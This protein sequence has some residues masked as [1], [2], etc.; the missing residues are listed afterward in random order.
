MRFSLVLSFTLVS[1]CL[2]AQR[3]SLRVVATL[4]SLVSHKQKSIDSAQQQLTA[5]LTLRQS[6]TLKV[7][8]TLDSTR[9]ALQQTLA[10][11][12]Q[13]LSPDI[14]QRKL[15]SLNN[16]GS[17][18]Y[19][20]SLN[21]RIASLQQKINNPFSKVENAV[22][23]KLSFLKQETGDP[24]FQQTLNLPEATVPTLGADVPGIDAGGLNIKSATSAVTDKLDL[25]GTGSLDK[26]AGQLNK[27]SELSGKVDDYQ[28]EIANLQESG[29]RDSKEL[30]A[31]AEKQLANTDAMQELQQQV[32]K[33]NLPLNSLKSEDAAKA[34]LQQ[35]AKTEVVKLAKDHFAGKEEALT[36]AMQKMSGL[37]AKYESLDSLNVPKRMPNTMKGKPLK[38]RIVLDLMVQI[39]KNK[40]WLLDFNPS[41][42]Y[43]LTGRWSI[44]AGWNQRLAFAKGL[45][46]VQEEEIY[47]WRSF[48]EFRW[49]K[50]FSLR[51]EAEQMYCF[52]V[53]NQSASKDGV[54][55]RWMW[56]AFA[57]IKKNYRISRR[58]EGT[59]SLLYLVYD[60]ADSSPYVN[61]V[62][63]RLGIHY[64]F[65]K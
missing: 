50:G 30:S 52:P 42:T 27:V 17:L 1:L 49:A 65:R 40:Y 60:P 33:S 36:A 35:Q 7:F 38:E 62:N 22:N 2:H 53:V 46:I 58:L 8:R 4:D 47:G 11:A 14:I 12:D 6:D 9:T 43:A 25:P 44:G 64:R 37:K 32:G 19:L 29:L 16:L 21:Q 55:A 39:Q 63:S 48:T 45:E 13:A 18:H 3:D 26:V 20:D 57:G 28:K 23:D 31:L 15:D 61:K 10:N 51:A 56:S 59:I 34:M 5:L 54:D 41:V 24:L